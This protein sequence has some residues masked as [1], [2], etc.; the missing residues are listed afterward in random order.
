MFLFGFWMRFWHG[1]NH[2]WT[3]DDPIMRTQ[4]GRRMQPGTMYVCPLERNEHTEIQLQ[5]RLMLMDQYARFPDVRDM[6]DGLRMVNYTWI[7]PGAATIS[8][9]PVN[10][11]INDIAQGACQGYGGD[12]VTAT[13]YYIIT[14]I[15]N[16][17]TGPQFDTFL[18]DNLNSVLQL[19][20]NLI[21]R[22]R[23]ALVAGATTEA[24]QRK[25]A[26]YTERWTSLQNP[27]QHLEPFN[28][29]RVGP[30]IHT[31]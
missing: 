13:A 29:R 18:R 21:E 30:N 24:D 7:N 2:P 17:T 9:T 6:V 22:D 25:L 4:A 16:F 26:A 28:P 27:V 8:A 14:S 19:E 31:F 1:P 10:N 12:Y 15:F 11:Y 3:Y 5:I 20:R 23:P